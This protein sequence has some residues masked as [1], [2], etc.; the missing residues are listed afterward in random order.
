AQPLTSPGAAGA[1]V[2]TRPAPGAPGGDLRRAGPPELAISQADSPPFLPGTSA[3][4]PA[5]CGTRTTFRFIR[6]RPRRRVVSCRQLTS[7]PAPVG[8]TCSACGTCRLTRNCRICGSRLF[9]SRSKWQPADQGPRKGL[10]TK[11]FPNKDLSQGTR[12]PGEKTA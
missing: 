1:P 11:A 9:K 3:S 4:R 12:K 10:G 8:Y 5:P 6:L 2:P 7:R